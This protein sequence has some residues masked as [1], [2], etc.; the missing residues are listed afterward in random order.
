MF[1]MF[2]VKVSVHHHH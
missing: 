1:V 2:A